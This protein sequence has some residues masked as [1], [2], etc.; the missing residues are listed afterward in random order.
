M[1]RSLWIGL[2]VVACSA[3]WVAGCGDDDQGGDEDENEAGSGG[4]GSG[5]SGS[6]GSNTGTGTSGSGASGSGACG[7]GA[8]GSGAGGA[9]PDNPAECPASAPAEDDSCTMDG[10]ECAYGT[11]ECQCEGSFQD[12]TMMAWDCST[13]GGG[14]EMQMCPATEPANGDECT[15][16]RGDCM[17]GTRICDCIRDS[18]MWACWD[19]ADC[20]ATPPENESPCDVVGMECEYGGGGG[21]GGGGDDCDCEESGWDCGGGDF[22]GDEDAGT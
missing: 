18:N 21:P 1:K 16:G 19:P 8:S 10:L 4:S 5:R 20:P 3:G 11:T 17:F 14:G 13:M 6:G 15:P 2:M 7:S 9:S 22:G 12:P